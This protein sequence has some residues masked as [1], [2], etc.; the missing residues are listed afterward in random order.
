MEPV[1]TCV[2]C[3]TRAPRSALLRVVAQ[4]DTLIPDE[5]AVLPGRGAWVHP[6]A[7]C[8]AAALRRRAF[9]R[10]LRVTTQ[11]DTRTFEQHP[12]RN[13]G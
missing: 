9:G 11:L 6:T 2:G 10:A 12:P 5:R 8:M 13:K 1:R 7:E 4:N 3:R